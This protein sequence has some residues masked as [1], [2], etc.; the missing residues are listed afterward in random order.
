MADT[1]KGNDVNIV[2]LGMKELTEKL[3]QGGE[4]AFGI[5]FVCGVHLA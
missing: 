2:L 4:G 3:S 5:V 1:R